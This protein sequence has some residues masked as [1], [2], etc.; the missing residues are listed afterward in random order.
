M[1]PKFKIGDV[2]KLNSNNYPLTI[3]EIRTGS[4]I[5]YVC[6]WIDN[7]GVPHSRTYAESM[8]MKYCE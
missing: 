2:V 6:D 1:N 5:E 3:N 8:I 7:S 4:P